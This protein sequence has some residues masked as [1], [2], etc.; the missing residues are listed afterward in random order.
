LPPTNHGVTATTGLQPATTPTTASAAPP[1]TAAPVTTTTTLPPA[2]PAAT[3][4]ATAAPTGARATY[5][6]GGGVV[7]V[8]CTGVASVELVAAVPF[9]G[10]QALVFTGGPNFVALSFVN[11]K[12]GNFPVGASCAF[13][14]PFQ[15]QYSGSHPGP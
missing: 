11:G 10:Y 12:G 3:P 15:F 14:Q 4:P 13:G 5:S 2:R 6:T 7:T 1:T 8:A 9:D